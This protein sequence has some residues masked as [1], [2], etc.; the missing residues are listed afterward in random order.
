M[1]RTSAPQ[2]LSDPGRQILEILQA[3]PILLV[4]EQARRRL[5]SA[6]FILGV[7]VALAIDPTPKSPPRRDHAADR[8][9]EGDEEERHPERAGGE[10]SDR[11]HRGIDRPKRSAKCFAPIMER[12]G[13]IVT[14]KTPFEGAAWIVRRIIESQVPQRLRGVFEHGD[15]VSHSTKTSNARAL[16]GETYTWSRQRG[17]AVARCRAGCAPL[18]AQTR[19]HSD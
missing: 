6:P 11:P 4:E 15:Q 19:W 12:R 5:S 10:Q 9:Q 13:L 8:D 2:L 17:R 7:S 18:L 14:A 1:Q 3:S 16:S